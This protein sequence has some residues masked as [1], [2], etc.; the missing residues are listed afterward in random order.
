MHGLAQLGLPRTVG[1]T[2]RV[3]EVWC[4]RDVRFAF[5]MSLVRAAAH[6]QCMCLVR[7]QNAMSR[8]LRIACDHHDMR[9]RNDAACC[10]TLLVKKKIFLTRHNEFQIMGQHEYEY[11]TPER[12]RQNGSS[13]R[14]KDVSTPHVIDPLPAAC[15]YDV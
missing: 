8:M 10:R 13:Q 9:S 15:W 7:G 5:V 12:D 6:L 3:C 2:R 14:Q 1:C 4:L 11:H